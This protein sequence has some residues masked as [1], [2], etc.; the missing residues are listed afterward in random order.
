MNLTL[1]KNRVLSALKVFS[2]AYKGYKRQIFILALLSAFGGLLEGV[3]VNALIP[4]LAFATGNYDTGEENVILKFVRWVFSATGFGFTLK[5]LL[6]FVCLLFIVKVLITILAQ[7]IDTRIVSGYEEKT[8]IDLV[9][10]ALNASWPYLLKQKVGYLDTILV[11]DIRKSSFLL[12]RLAAVVSNIANLSA[13]LLVAVSISWPITATALAVGLFLI[14][15]LIPL[16]HKIRAFSKKLVEMNKKTAH[17]VNENII[18]AK[19]IKSMVVED[20]VAKVGKKFF[21]ALKILQI[22]TTLLKALLSAF[23]Q[24]VS[25]IFISIIFAVFY[26]TPGF[27]FAALAVIIYLI[28]RIFL[29]VQSTQS[30]LQGISETYPYLTAILNY[31]NDAAKNK[32]KDLGEKKFIFEKDL[33]FDGVSFAYDNGAVVLDNLNFKIKKGEMLGLVG[34]SGSGKTTI[35]DLILRLFQPVRGRI[36][37]DGR[38]IAEVDIKEWR[39]N[40]GYV[41]QDIFLKNDSFE[42][43]IK[44]YD[45]LIT[46]ADMI[47]AAKMAN[48]YDLIAGSPQGFKT[49]VGERGVMISGG[50]RQ[51]IALARV[52]AR[53]PKILILDEATSS[54]DAESEAVIQKVIE[55]LKGKMTVLIIAHRLATVINCDKLF[56]LERGRIIE[57]GSPD[58]L[59]SNKESHFYRLY[60][61]G[62]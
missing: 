29:Y 30:S 42:N 15:S 50:Q 18:G 6:I 19:T 58:Y 56:V 17:Y 3:G 11:Y 33:Q 21:A 57:E 32:E 61:I 40:I 54:L 43:N 13:Y 14:I 20:A 37:L 47:R 4:V 23:S 49:I 10:Q 1:E 22:R 53:N 45:E 44:F 12:E 48:I 39:R 59:L 55:N 2:V 7:Y 27:N 8:R 26:K 51:R 62:A 25:V 5:Y 35:V 9:G 41:S 16:I 34:Q 60:N 46:E 52:L 31:K 24:P 28:Q 36:L 38:D